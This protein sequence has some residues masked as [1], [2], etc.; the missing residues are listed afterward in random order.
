MW[1]GETR[2]AIEALEHAQRIDPALNAFDRLALGLAYYLEGR[3][4]AAVQTLELNL[5]DGVGAGPTRVI[6]AAAYARQ[7]RNEDAA[8]MAANVLRADPGFDPAAFGSKLA[9]PAHIDELRVGLRK[10]GLMTDATA[11][12]PPG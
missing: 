1:R 3:Y 2:A 8:R 11:R 10:A 5:R 6:L 4:D 9:N 7:D 12:P